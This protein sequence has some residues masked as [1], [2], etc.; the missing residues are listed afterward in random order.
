[1]NDQL[2]R[3]ASQGTLTSRKRAAGKPALQGLHPPK[4]REPIAA[5][6]IDVVPTMHVSASATP[7]SDTHGMK[8]KEQS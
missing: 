1:M 3:V 5:R 2:V 6:K 4:K 8:K 7:S